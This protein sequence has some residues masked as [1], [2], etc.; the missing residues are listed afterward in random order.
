MGHKENIELKKIKNLLKEI[1]ESIEYIDDYGYVGCFELR[2][3]DIKK[4]SNKIIKNL[5]VS[6]KEFNEIK[7][8]ICN[9]FE[10]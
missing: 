8:S 6:E 1:H 4:K 10:H 5:K 7:I 2:T 9:S 3:D